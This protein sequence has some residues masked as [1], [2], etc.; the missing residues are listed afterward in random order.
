MELL[1]LAGKKGQGVK[2]LYG[3]KADQVFVGVA[4]GLSGHYYPTIDLFYPEDVLPTVLEIVRAM[5][6][7]EYLPK[8]YI[9]RKGRMAYVAVLFSLKPVEEGLLREI[10]L[11]QCPKQVSEEIR[12]EEFELI[13]TGEAE[14][15]TKNLLIFLD[16]FG[17]REYFRLHIARK[18]D[19]EAELLWGIQLASFED[20]LPVPLT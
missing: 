20:Q 9:E 10:F 14:F 5:E 4:R 2:L 6:S 16:F 8:A 17:T 11:R 3:A 1:I 12:N 19:G 15:A 7:H 18:K 13:M